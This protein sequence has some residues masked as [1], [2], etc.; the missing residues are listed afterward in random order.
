MKN[1]IYIVFIIILFSASCGN[2][3]EYP[4][5]PAIEFKRVELR[6]SI[7]K[8]E[9]TPYTVKLCR[10][11]F[12]VTDG[13]G[14]IGFMLN[15]DTSSY[16]FFADIYEKKNGELKKL[17]LSAPYNYRIPYIEP[18]GQNKLLKAQIMVDFTFNYYNQALLF[19]SIMYEF[20][21]ND[22]AGNLSNKV[23]TPIFSLKDEG[24][25]Y[26]TN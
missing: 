22:R 14:N 10:V 19:D 6:D 8:I 15:E 23:R 4:D 18:A 20:Y 16:N 12:S 5:I 11:V 21:I 24:I 7:G 9:E 26:E 13:D 1:F 2:K 25:V 3:D 17:E